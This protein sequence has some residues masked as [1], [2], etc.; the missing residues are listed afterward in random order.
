MGNAV[1][2]HHVGITAPAEVLDKVAA[3]YD[4]VLGL[5]PGYRPEFGGIGGSWL[6]CGDQPIIHLLEDPNRAGEKSG[7]FDHVA[8]RCSDLEG[9]ISNLKE[10]EIDFLQREIKEVGQ[11]QLF[12]TDPS[13]TTV[14]L[15]FLDDSVRESDA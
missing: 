10:N 9:V 2:V 8:L 1:F 5:K 11:V 15:N 6:Y 14:E 4:R 3:F 12:V 13:G 7:H